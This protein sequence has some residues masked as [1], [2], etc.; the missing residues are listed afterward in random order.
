MDI[1]MV[2]EWTLLV[3][4]RFNRARYEPSRHHRWA[5]KRRAGK[6]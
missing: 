3:Q 2:P 5:W 1:F 4:V 6:Y